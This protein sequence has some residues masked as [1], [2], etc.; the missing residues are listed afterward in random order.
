MWWHPPPILPSPS[1]STTVSDALRV[2][3]GQDWV[4]TGD[5]KG[6]SGR[7]CF[8]YHKQVG[9]MSRLFSGAVHG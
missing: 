4:G 8:T 7:K 9:K 3:E 2:E 1:L 6:E 5:R